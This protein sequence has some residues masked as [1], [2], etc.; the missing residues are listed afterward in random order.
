M[1]IERAWCGCL[2]CG[3]N[4]Y[5]LNTYCRVHGYVLAMAKESTHDI[6]GIEKFNRW[7]RRER[8]VFIKR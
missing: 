2:M 5:K 1:E 4:V 3:N 8:K 6:N 7:C